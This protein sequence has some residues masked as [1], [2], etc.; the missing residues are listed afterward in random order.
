MSKH[1]IEE[2][3]DDE[4]LVNVCALQLIDLHKCNFEMF[5]PEFKKNKGKLSLSMSLSPEIQGEIGEEGILASDLEINIKG[6]TINNEDE[7]I[8][9][10]DFVIHIQYS[11]K[12]ISDWDE[13]EVDHF[14]QRNM[15]MHVWPYARELVT[16]MTKRAGLP[17]VVLPLLPLGVKNRT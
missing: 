6:T 1:N 16:S 12:K 10:F 14:I 3:T 2:T 17:D 13:K 15:T 9:S 5:L 8:F 4:S 11:I 7:K